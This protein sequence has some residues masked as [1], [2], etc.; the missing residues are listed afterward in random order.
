LLV[1]EL[2]LH[3]MLVTQQFH[4]VLQEVAVLLL[5]QVHYLRLLQAEQVAQDFY[6]VQ[7]AQVVH[8]QI[9]S[10][11]AVLDMEAV[12]VEWVVVVPQA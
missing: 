9:L 5:V 10:L 6:L 1:V 11:L 8:R 4:L 12:A 7:V 2:A 3:L